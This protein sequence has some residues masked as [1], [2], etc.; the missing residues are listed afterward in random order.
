MSTTIENKLTIKTNNIPRALVQPWELSK[1]ELKEFDYLLD[2]PESLDDS[3]LEQAWMN[4]GAQF[5][6]YKGELHDLSEFV[7]IVPPGGKSV[8]FEHHDVSGHFN[9]WHGIRTDSYFSGL[10]VRWAD[11]SGES[12]IVGR[13]YC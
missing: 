1:A 4:S 13:Y 10:L 7:R 11:D 2:N 12:V 6:R 8:G 3:E 9:G 5:I